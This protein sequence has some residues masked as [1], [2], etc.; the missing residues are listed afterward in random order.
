MHTRDKR[1]DTTYKVE[2][3]TDNPELLKPEARASE[4]YLSETVKWYLKPKLKIA[5]YVSGL[6]VTH[7]KRI[8]KLKTA[9]VFTQSLLTYSYDVCLPIQPA[10]K[11]RGGH[12]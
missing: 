12:H 2:G 11:L 6:L 5:R 7:G 10:H 4:P 1:F 3:R 8:L 9:V